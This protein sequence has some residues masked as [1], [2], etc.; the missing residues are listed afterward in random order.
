MAAP[1]ECPHQEILPGVCTSR[2]EV[3]P[4]TLVRFDEA[5]FVSGIPSASL[6]DASWMSPSSQSRIFSCWVRFMSTSGVLL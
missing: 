2:R 5:R 6:S 1:K 4:E 3:N